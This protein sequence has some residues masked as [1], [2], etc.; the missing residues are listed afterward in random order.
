MPFKHFWR[1]PTWTTK[2]NR[3]LNL[4]SWQQSH[5]NNPSKNSNRHNFH[6]WRR[7]PQQMKALCS[8]L[9]TSITRPKANTLNA[10]SR[11]GNNSSNS[12]NNRQT[13]NSLLTLV[14][15]LSNSTPKHQ[16]KRLHHTYDWLSTVRY[17]RPPL[18]GLHIT[19]L[20]PWT[21]QHSNTSSANSTDELRMRSGSVPRPNL[22]QLNIASHAP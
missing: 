21:W 12:N 13:Y 19:Q 4:A 7:N 2:L 1:W 9:N 17:N 14:F 10:C 11:T 18:N 22:S 5:R 20:V 16:T 15:E 3:A 8:S 6:S